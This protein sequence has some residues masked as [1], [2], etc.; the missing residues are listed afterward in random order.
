MDEQNRPSLPGYTGTNKIDIAVAIGKGVVGAAPLVGPL[1][2][3]VLSV[4]I[5]NQRIDRITRLIKK[6]DEKVAAL[7]W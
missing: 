5:P 3:E 4:L 7:E 2:A 6:L 1:I